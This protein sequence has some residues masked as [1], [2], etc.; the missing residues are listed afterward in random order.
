MEILAL[1]TSRYNILGS[2]IS[3]CGKRCFLD[4]PEINRVTNF[5]KNGKKSYLKTYKLEETSVNNVMY[6]EH[7]VKL[8]KSS[9]SQR[10]VD[11]KVLETLLSAICIINIMY[12]SGRTYDN[13]KVHHSL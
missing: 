5:I 10:L 13:K 3:P 12:K 11:K 6:K 4:W 9:L 8:R 2:P 7:H 1:F